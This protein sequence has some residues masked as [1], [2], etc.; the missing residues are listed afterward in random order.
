[1]GAILAPN[2]KGL[3]EVADSVYGADSND[4]LNKLQGELMNALDIIQ[5]YQESKSNYF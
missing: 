1:M 2:N 3:P 5:N 4:Y